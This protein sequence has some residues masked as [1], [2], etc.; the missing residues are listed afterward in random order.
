MDRAGKPP[1]PPR[2]PPGEL[3]PEM[4]RY[5]ALVLPF[6][7]QIALNKKVENQL[8]AEDIAQRVALGLT[9]KWLADPASFDGAT[10]LAVVIVPRVAHLVLKHF[11]S[12]KRRVVRE[13]A[14]GYEYARSAE[15]EPAQ[16]DPEREAR[17]NALWRSVGSALASCSAGTRDVFFAVF[18]DGL[19]EAEVARRFGLNP[20]TV[21]GRCHRVIV[22]LRTGA[23]I[24]LRALR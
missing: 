4:E 18:Q 22:K 2:A 23:D 17:L 8:E 1:A 20:S 15:D 24:N 11:R 19:D 21:R 9:R 5:L 7:A 6:A 13:E 3:T 14:F 12:V 16:P 10:P